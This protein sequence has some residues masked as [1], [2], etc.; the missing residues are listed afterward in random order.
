MEMTDT[1]N[2]KVVNE[3]SAKDVAYS[4]TARGLGERPSA[5]DMSHLDDRRQMWGF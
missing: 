4:V 1:A 2:R 3:K 5:P